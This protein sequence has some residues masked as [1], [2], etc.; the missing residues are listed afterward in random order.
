MNNYRKAREQKG[1]TA[2]EA[3]TS[4]GISITTLSSWENDKT[5]PTALKLI[6]L[7]RLYECSADELLGVEPLKHV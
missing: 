6:E 2:Q 7:C 3:A 1:Y 5:Y 4:L